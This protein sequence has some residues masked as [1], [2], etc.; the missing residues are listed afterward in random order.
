MD[1]VR[2]IRSRAAIGDG[3]TT[4]AMPAAMRE[5]RERQ[6]DD[7]GGDAGRVITHPQK[8]RPTKKAAKAFARH[9]HV[10]PYE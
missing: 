7:D 10:R 8:L 3:M 4:V 6:R 9:L 1:P 5:F 2:R